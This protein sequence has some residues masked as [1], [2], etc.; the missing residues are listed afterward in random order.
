MTRKI[1]ATLLVGVLLT[2]G[3][4]LTADAQDM[5]FGGEKDVAFAN[6]LWEAMDGYEDW[7]MKSDL[8][9]GQSP[10]GKFLRL[11]YNV[12]NIEGTPYHVIVKDNFGGPDL[13]TVS[14][15][16][17]EYLAAIT[18]MVQREAGY[19]P[20]NGD[21]FWVKYMPDGT[22]EKNAKG[23]AMAGRVARGADKGCI[24]CH[25]QARDNDLV[26]TNDR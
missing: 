17:G 20:E 15:S 8:Y 25:H 13:E 1:T 11:Y 18:P 23:V 22:I 6:K 3:I 10:H 2:G 16:P 26:F 5:P 9:P 24:A 19:D 12:V 21:W 14:A 4:L 7:P